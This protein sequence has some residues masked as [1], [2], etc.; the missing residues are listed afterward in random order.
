M[1]GWIYTLYCTTK[2]MISSGPLMFVYLVVGH[3]EAI[4]MWQYDI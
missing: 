4:D 1:I 3:N 2:I